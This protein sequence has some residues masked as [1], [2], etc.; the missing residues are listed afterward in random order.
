MNVAV[1]QIINRTGIPELSKLYKIQFATLDE[2]LEALAKKRGKL[3]PGGTPD[4]YEAAKVVIRDW[5]K[6][7]I[8]H[9][10]LPTE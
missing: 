6:N 10:L 9:Y 2:L 3:L 7:K 1:R 5:Q 4:V 8:P